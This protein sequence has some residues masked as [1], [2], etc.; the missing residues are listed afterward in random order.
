LPK[1]LPKEKNVEK[2]CPIASLEDPLKK[3]DY[4][5]LEQLKP[6]ETRPSFKFVN[7]LLNTRQSNKLKESANLHL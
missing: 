6:E 1:G 3:P 4:T 5:V 2:H 7:V